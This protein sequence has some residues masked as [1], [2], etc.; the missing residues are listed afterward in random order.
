MPLVIAT[1]RKQAPR[2]SIILRV[3]HRQE[4]VDALE[5][6]EVDLAITILPDAPTTLKRAT[7]FHERWVSL[8][9]AKHP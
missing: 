9:S 1:L 2:I 3:M 4:L 7:L 8:V 6:G 5:R